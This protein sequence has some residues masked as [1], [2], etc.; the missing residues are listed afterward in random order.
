MSI[1]FRKFVRENSRFEYKSRYSVDYMLSAVKKDLYV[2]LY[3]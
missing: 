3:V 1:L 2:I